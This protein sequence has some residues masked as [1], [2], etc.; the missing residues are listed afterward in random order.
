MSKGIGLI[1][2]NAPSDTLNYKPSY[3]LETE[4]YFTFFF[5]WFGVAFGGKVI[6]SWCSLNKDIGNE[7]SVATR[8]IICWE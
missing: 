3:V 1:E 8:D 6:H 5:I 4:P 2:L 7:D